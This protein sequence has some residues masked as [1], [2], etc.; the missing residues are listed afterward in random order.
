MT[1]L[2]STFREYAMSSYLTV[3]RTQKNA[4][5][6]SM[7]ICR[8]NIKATGCVE[9]LTDQPGSSVRGRYT[10][11][12]LEPKMKKQYLLLKRWIPLHIA[13]ARYPSYVATKPQNSRKYFL[14]NTKDLISFLDI[15]RCCNSLFFGLIMKQNQTSSCSW[16]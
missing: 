12:S 2:I 11:M 3:G 16:L 9:K 4:R 15:L 14:K 13:E 1:K 6:M 7:E 10:V 8:K 5:N